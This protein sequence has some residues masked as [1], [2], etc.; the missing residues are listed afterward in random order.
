MPI[1]YAFT[2]PDGRMRRPS[3]TMGARP[4]TPR[5]TA[6]P[7]RSP[8]RLIADGV[9][10]QRRIAH[11]DKIERP[12]LRA[13]VRRRQGQRRDGLGQLAARAARGRADR[14]RRRSRDA[15]RRGG[16]LPGDREDPR[17]AQDRPQDRGARRRVIPTGS[18]SRPGAIASRRA[19]P[20]LPIEPNDTAVQFYTSGTTGLP[21]GAR[22]HQRATSR[23]D[24][25][26][27]DQRAGCWRRACPT[28]SAC[29]CS[30]SAAPAGASPASSPG[31]PTTSCASSS[32]RRSS[33]SSS[34]SA[35]R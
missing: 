24:A 10:P 17:R 32:R 25:A 22:A 21:K 27:V 23:C 14:Q 7:A 11:L 2:A 5:S 31:R 8:T 19:D 12:V 28:W 30:I 1:S 15:V 6:P 20:R 18:R 16:V 29:R 26:A 4:P 33:R 9:Q 3:S 13:A 35:C 34:A